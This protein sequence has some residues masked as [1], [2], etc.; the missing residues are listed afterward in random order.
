MGG[1]KVRIGHLA[2]IGIAFLAGSL[3]GSLNCTATE[4]RFGIDNH[5]RTGRWT[6]VAFDSIAPGQIFEVET[7]DGESVRYTHRVEVPVDWPADRSLQVYLPAGPIGSPVEVFEISGDDAAAVRTS[8]MRRRLVE[9]AVPI[10]QS[11]VVAVGSAIGLDEIGRNELLAIDSALATSV[12]SVA[13]SMPD[14]SVGYDGVDYVILSG[15]SR[16]C[17]AGMS[18]DQIKAL[19]QWVLGGGKCVVT[20]GQQGPDLLATADWLSDWIA[21]SPPTESIAVE[22]AA[23]ETFVS[24][25]APIEPFQATRFTP[26]DAIVVLAGRTDGRTGSRDTL[27][28]ITVH[29]VGLGRVTVLAA[30]L[31]EAPLVDW[32]QRTDLINR[33]IPE[34]VSEQ[35]RPGDGPIAAEVRYSELAGQVRTHIDRFVTAGRARFSVIAAIMLA[36]VGLIGP[37]DYFLINRWLGRPLLGWVSFPVTVIAFTAALA[38]WNQQP[39][40]V[41]ANQITVVDIDPRT[42]TGRG[43]SW[44]Q[45]Y[46]NRAG[47]FDLNMEVTG[48][49][50]DGDSELSVIG[51]QGFPG[52]VYGGIEVAG[53]D[54]RLPAYRL[55]G[56]LRGGQPLHSTME[57]V[58]FAP[59]SSR[60]VA[61]RWHFAANQVVTS[62]LRRRFGSDL[63]VGQLV[64]PFEADLLDGYL[65]YRN[66][67]Y[68]LPT[69]VPAGGTIASVD[70]LPTKNFRW[71]LNRRQTTEDASRSEPWNPAADDDFDR[72]ME[73]VLFY[74]AAGGIKYVGLNNREL[75]DLDLSPALGLDRA[76]LVGR[77]SQPQTRLL[78]DGSPLEAKDIDHANYVRVL[79]PVTGQTPVPP[80]EFR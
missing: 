60:G 72:L 25:R 74:G 71:R 21:E 56:A 27:P 3:A 78:V 69:R 43:F 52:T 10:D 15:S 70:S 55:T 49:V 35:L 26:R 62:D 54:I 31:D 12:V 61:T 73:I 16:Q 20:L 40:T 5:Y 8:M 36:L 41:Q 1:G 57:G 13:A 66:L 46:T 19:R 4:I 33:M 80:S 23:L 38:V 28:L 7:L 37:I 44:A 24:A 47:R 77:L 30:G 64:N 59:G 65:V 39:S 58:P 63:L 34:L 9:G 32:K 50:T 45:V 29:M 2:V 18:E 51:P 67:T 17:L 48:G 14:A 68:L 53:E 42:G 79:L 11:W 76:V 6:P 22:A 75:G